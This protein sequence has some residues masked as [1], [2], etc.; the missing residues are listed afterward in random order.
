MNGF[1][2]PQAQAVQTSREGKQTCFVTQP[3]ESVD[4]YMPLLHKWVKRRESDIDHEH[5][6]RVAQVAGNRSF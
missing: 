1:H 5:T 2:I 6:S 4:Q 3:L